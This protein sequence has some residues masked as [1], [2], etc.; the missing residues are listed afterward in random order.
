MK[1]LILRSTVA[2]GNDVEAGQ[3][4]E[5]RD[6]TARYL[7]QL[8]KASDQLPTPKPAAKKTKANGA[9]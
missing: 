7:M 4:V 6:Q 8:G 5:V 1:V 2:D 9:D 3:V